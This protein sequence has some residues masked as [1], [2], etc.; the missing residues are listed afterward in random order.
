MRK[1]TAI[2]CLSILFTALAF[3]SFGQQMDDQT[4][5]LDKNEIEDINLTLKSLTHSEQLSIGV[6]MIETTAPNNIKEYTQS[7]F[8]GASG[9]NTLIIIAKKDRKVW[10]A[11][12]SKSS[13][14]LNEDAIKNIT[15]N[16]MVPEFRAGRFASGIKK[17][18][19]A[20][21]QSVKG[22][23]IA[24]NQ[25]FQLQ[26]YPLIS[27]LITLIILSIVS[28]YV[29]DTRVKLVIAVVVAGAFWLLFGSITYAILMLILSLFPLLGRSARGGAGVYGGGYNDG[30]EGAG[31]NN[32]ESSF[33]LG[34]GMFSGGG[35]SG[36]WRSFSLDAHKKFE[37]SP[38]QKESVEQA[39]KDLE[40]ESS[41]EIVV[42]FA[43]KS[44][45]YDH[46]SWR[47]TALLGLL[48]L[49]SVI[50]LSYVW[51][52]PASLTIMHITISLLLLMLTGL[53]V[54]YFFPNVR[55]AF[56]PLNIMDHRVITK[57]RDIFL[58]EEIFDTVERT[59]I[60]IYISE[61]EQRVQILGDKGISS[62]INQED[63]NQILAT[64]TESI[65][66]GKPA[67]GLVKAIGEC[68][69]LLLANDF[70]VRSDDTNELSDEMII[71][72]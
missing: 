17:G 71:E 55:L 69:D 34:G 42:Y 37:F 28:G 51:L 41:G 16:I 18:I 48:G 67:E 36:H 25:T 2:I 38:Q 50:S 57:A 60:L 11:S 47:L 29:Q 72:E 45:S 12:D 56:V 64:V 23:A 26:N 59:G 32:S 20:S 52:L 9:L 62:A 54:C 4:K 40:L 13:N 30:N 21:V 7:A 1:T 27:I 58:Q 65:K 15:E 43:R 63:W 61:I 33:S 31:G 66:K 24:K 19:D 5:S 22:N 6:R 68:K 10:I 14:Q 70:I 44:D 35:A 49:L 53:G 8:E 39:I 3:S 46:G